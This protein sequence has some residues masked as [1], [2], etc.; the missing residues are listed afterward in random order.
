MK[1]VSYKQDSG[2]IC[3]GILEGALIHPLPLSEGDDVLATIRA[4]PFDPQPES[5]PVALDAVTLV[6]SL[7]HPPRILGTG[8]NYREHVAASKMAVQT[9]PTVF[10]KL[11]SSLR[12]PDVEVSLPGLGS[13]RNRTR[14]A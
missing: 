14:S 3:V 11:A 10:F 1:L 2:A 8:L 5:A 9:V 7:Q 6:A 12:G 13:L 4:E